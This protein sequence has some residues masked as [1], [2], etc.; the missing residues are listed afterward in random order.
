MSTRRTAPADAPPQ[1]HSAGAVLEAVRRHFP[2]PEWAVLAGVS[3]ATGFGARRW[4][5]ALAM[6]LWPSRG[7]A[8][9][10][11]EIKISRSDL[12]RELDDP[13]KA[14]TIA[15]YCDYWWLALGSERVLGDLVVPD[16]WG[17]LVPQQAGANI[18][19]RAM[20]QAVDMSAAREGGRAPTLPRAFVAAMLRRAVDMVD[21]AHKKTVAPETLEARVAAETEKTL[22]ERTWALEQRALR[23]EAELVDAKAAHESLAPLLQDTAAWHPAQFR[24]LVAE[25]LAVRAAAD[26]A[27][28]IETSRGAV[29]RMLHSTELARAAFAEAA[30]AAR[31]AD[32]ARRAPDERADLQI[33]PR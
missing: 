27:R 31:A 24:A 9:H 20:R 7:L 15:R 30:E 5:D 32:E 6:N 10:G 14:E 33:Q 2:H 28:T 25:V 13:D 29:D 17:I 18:R 26:L 19:L 16:G 1:L 12:R 23:A 21:E 3:N 4:S 8:L 22:R 11:I